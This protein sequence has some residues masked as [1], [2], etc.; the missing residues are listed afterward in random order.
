M[1]VNNPERLDQVRRILEATGGVGEVL[2]R[3]GQKRYGL[4]HPR[5][6]DL[7][8]LAEP[9][10]WF[11]YYYWQDDAKAPDFARTVDIHR[12]P[13]YDPA[14]LFL[15]P[16]LKNPKLKAA[17]VLVKKKLGFRYLMDVIGLDATLV[18]G[19]HGLRS[20]ALDK[21]P[22]FVTQQAEHLAGPHIR[23]TDVFETVLNHLGVAEPLLER[24][25]K[26]VS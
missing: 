23:A 18:R 10:A 6:G 4:D 12:K 24:R 21:A 15:D 22:V 2:D 1:Y 9:D 8:A 7:V 14:E 17:G 5:S 13:G 19:S 25:M 16:E 11:T 20:R 3:E 26:A